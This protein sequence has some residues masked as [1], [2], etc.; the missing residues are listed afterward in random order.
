MVVFCLEHHLHW[1]ILFFFSLF[2]VL[3]LVDAA[4]P[5]QQ[6]EP[7]RQTILQVEGVKVWAIDSP[8]IFHDDRHSHI[9]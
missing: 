6:L 3:E 7:I 1:W 9:Y 2:S 8:C 4:I 5:A